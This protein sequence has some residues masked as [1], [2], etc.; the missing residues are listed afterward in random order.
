MPEEIEK[1][2]KKK[3]G[4]LKLVGI[5]LVVL[6]LLGGGGF[7]AWKF[8]FQVKPDGTGPA[9]TEELAP[10]GAVHPAT[11][12][13][14]SQ[15]IGAVDVIK[16]EP[17][18][19]NLADPMGRRYLKITL[20]VEVAAGTGPVLEASL[21]RAKDSLLLLLSSK[22]YA[23]ISSLDQKLELKNEIMERLNQVVGKG[24]VKNIYFTEFVIQ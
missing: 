14:D 11:Q 3:G 15:A 22:F 24:K 6:V 18:V 13:Q 10:D 4:F 20:E 5:A 17:F 8:L 12:D 9:G 21:S 1:V 2:E 23:E 19:V 16:F 7:A